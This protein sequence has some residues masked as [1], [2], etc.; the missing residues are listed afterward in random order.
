[1]MNI[2]IGDDE[3]L[4]RFQDARTAVLW[5]LR[6]RCDPEFVQSIKSELGRRI[7]NDMRREL[8]EVGAAHRRYDYPA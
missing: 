6:K 7:Q 2:Q 5:L 8:V 3:E 1:M 4:L